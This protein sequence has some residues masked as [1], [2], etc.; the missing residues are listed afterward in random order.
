[1]FSLSSKKIVPKTHSIDESGYLGINEIEAKKRQSLKLK[2][3]EMQ[4]GRLQRRLQS[5]AKD[6]VLGS[7]EKIGGVGVSDLDLAG[8]GIPM[9]SLY[10]AVI[11]ITATMLH[12]QGHAISI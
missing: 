9:V 8:W 2:S 4:K 7:V 10:Y 12:I 6:V 5:K 11:I 1:M 3:I